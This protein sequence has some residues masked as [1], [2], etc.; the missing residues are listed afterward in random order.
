MHI[1][2]SSVCSI[3]TCPPRNIK[4]DNHEH[5]TC[6]QKSRKEQQIILLRMFHF[7]FVHHGLACMFITWPHHVQKN[8][9][10]LSWYRS[11]TW[12]LW[13]SWFLDIIKCPFCY[14]LSNISIK[15][16]FLSGKQI[17]MMSMKMYQ[18]MMLIIC[19]CI[20]NNPSL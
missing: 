5:Y 11:L 16:K 8:V 3:Y 12:Y 4:G 14:C 20:W 17:I 9:S 7:V 10:S 13:T 1:S 19:K 6:N 2:L 15:Q 18:F